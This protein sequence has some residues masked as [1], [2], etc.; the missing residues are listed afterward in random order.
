MDE[1][2]FADVRRLLEPRSV[3]VVGASDEPG[4]LGGT[5][6]RYL[7]KF[8]YAGDVW[9]VNPRRETVAGL[10]CFPS[11]SA[12]PGTAD[13]AVIA[14]KAELVPGVVRSC[15]EAG[16]RHGVAWA[17][18]FAEVGGEG[19]TRQRELADAC[20]D[21]GFALL[22]PNCLGMINTSAGLTATFASFLAETD[23]L[24]AGPV[25]MVSQ[26]GGMGTQTQA[27]AARMGIGFRYMVNSGN[28]VGLTAA[29]LISAFA[30]DPGTS[31]I[32]AYLEGVR[33]GV[34]LRIAFEKARAAG[35]PVV[36]LMGGTA[37]ASARAAGAH[38][39]ALVGGGR[40]RRAVLAGH[41]VIQVDSLEEL[42]DVVALLATTERHKLPAG[43]GTAVVTFGGG[44][45]VLAADQ[46]A[47]A[48]LTTPSLAPETVGRLREIAPPIAA[49]SNPVDLTPRC[50][51]ARTTGTGSPRCCTRSRTTAGSTR[52][53]STS[54]R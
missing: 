39:A 43:P 41:G 2:A 45:G 37:P 5:A 28:E 38:T 12:L 36:V 30:D 6:V 34:R 18:G 44:G 46:A 47:T 21:T 49:L 14:V 32:A 51:C 40:A 53:C 48:G 3:A 4:N 15:A 17:G 42:L 22:G 52:C 24:P 35:K 16:I 54:D 8:K 29:D 31:V 1:P 23:D 27:L 10:P 25:S 13:L 26:S 20:Q 7:Q 33:D 19:S 9:P 11:V 50:T